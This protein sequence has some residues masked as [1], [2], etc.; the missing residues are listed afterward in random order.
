MKK[1]QE[2]TKLKSRSA[3]LLGN[4]KARHAVYLKAMHQ[5]EQQ[6]ATALTAFHD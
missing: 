1:H 6:M 2:Q 4:A 3:G 5:T